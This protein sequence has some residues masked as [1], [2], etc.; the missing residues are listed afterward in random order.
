LKVTFAA[1]PKRTSLN[2]MGDVFLPLCARGGKRAEHDVNRRAFLKRV[3]GVTAG[4][5]A[6]ASV[7][8][9]SAE[10]TGGKSNAVSSLPAR[11]LPRSGRLMPIL[12]FGSSAFGGYGLKGFS[13]LSRAEQVRA[14]R[15]A[16]Q[17][18]IRYFDTAHYYQS[19][20]VLGDALK[21]VRDRVYLATKTHAISGPVARQHVEGSLRQLRTDALDCVKLHVPNEYDFAMRVLDELEKMRDEGKLRHIGMSNHIHFELAHRLIDTGRLDEVLL[22]RCRFPKGYEETVSPRNQ[23]FREMA[24]ARAHEL[25]MNIIGMK[26]LGAWIFGHHAVDLVPDYDARKAAR[27]P[28]AAIRWAFSDARFH[29]YLVGVSMVSDIDDDVRI[30]SGD[31]TLTDEDRALLAEFCDKASSAPRIKQCPEPYEYPDSAVYY[32]PGRRETWMR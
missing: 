20:P 1:T 12:G 2:I 6:F 31:L 26:A 13:P 19:E 22:A 27:L 8:A 29:V 25:K 4:F 10:E 28:G 15:Y 11:R 9:A 32:E 24:I 21:D 14:V 30:C 23:E 3:I 16:Y 5:G 18:G 7:P 17:K